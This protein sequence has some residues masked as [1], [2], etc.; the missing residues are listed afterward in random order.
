MLQTSTHPAE[1]Y[2]AALCK[3]QTAP[4]CSCS[5][6]GPDEHRHTVHNNL[7]SEK[8]TDR[9][10]FSFIMNKVHSSSLSTCITILSHCSVYSKATHHALHHTHLCAAVPCPAPSLVILSGHRKVIGGHYLPC[11]PLPVHCAFN[12]VAQRISFW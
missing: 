4:D 10:H 3:R 6:P 7:T 5:S 2:S 1:G 8:D 11:S 9:F 12:H